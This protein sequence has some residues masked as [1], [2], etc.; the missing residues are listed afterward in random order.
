MTEADV[1][2]ALRTAM[3]TTLL[4]AAP[5]LIAA[6]VIGLVIALLQALTQIQEMTLTFVPKFVVVVIAAMV[7]APAFLMSLQHLSEFVFDR[8]ANGWAA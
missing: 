1:V 7:F 2:D 3:R 4:I 6:T 5:P 8:M